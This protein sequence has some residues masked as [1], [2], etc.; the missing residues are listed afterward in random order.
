[1]AYNANILLGR[2]SKVYGFE[3]AVT[4]KLEKTFIGKIPDMESVFLEID[5]KPVPFFIEESDYPGGDT[6]MLKFTWYNA[7]DKVCDF[8][9]CRVFLTS[10]VR[11]ESGRD[12][13]DLIGYEVCLAGSTLIGTIAEITENPGQYLLNI[14]TPGGKNVLI[15]FHEDFIISVEKRKK[16]IRMDLPEGL[17]DLNQ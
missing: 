5:G 12:I 6:L 1:M 9:G 16:I 14:S 4:V 8:Q 10:G 11:P 15:P 7:Y 2:I 17:L 3:G 13:K